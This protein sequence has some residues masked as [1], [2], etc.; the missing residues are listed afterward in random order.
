MFVNISS[1]GLLDGVTILGMRGFGEQ[2][3]I[4]TAEKGLLVLDEKGVVSAVGPFQGEP[5][6]PP[7]NPNGPNLGP[8]GHPGA[9]PK[10][11]PPLS[12][13]DEA[14]H[15]AIARTRTNEP[16]GNRFGTAQWIGEDDA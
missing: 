2:L 8:P 9:P 5:H 13:E 12:A 3:L 10:L 1:G 4:A 16:H 15:R 7:P 6:P 11:R 14:I